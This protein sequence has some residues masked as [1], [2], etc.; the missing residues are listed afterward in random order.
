M[1]VGGGEFTDLLVRVSLSI[2]KS[3]DLV[4]YKESVSAGLWDST[5]FLLLRRNYPRTDSHPCIKF[6]MIGI[7]AFLYANSMHIFCLLNFEEF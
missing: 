4:I 3:F 6:L 2:N 7:P 5:I 1:G